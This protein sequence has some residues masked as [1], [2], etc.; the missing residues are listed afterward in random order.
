MH[1]TFS[2]Q[3]IN[4]G[5]QVE[6]DIIKAVS[7][8]VF[9][10][11]CHVYEY[12]TEGYTS[13]FSWVSDELLGGLAAP[14]FMFAMGFGMKYSRNHSLKSQ[15]WRGVKLLTYGQLLNIF[16]YAIP[17]QLHWVITGDESY[18]VSHALNFS[19]D[20]MQFAG[21][22]F[23]LVTLTW[24]LKFS[25]SMTLLLA[26]LMSLI[27]NVL[28]GVQ[29]D[30]YAFD[31]F[32]GVF[33][34]TETESYFPLFNWFLFVAAGKMF[35]K[36]YKRLADKE[37][38]Y[39][40][41]APISALCFAGFIYVT[42]STD[43]GLFRFH[44]VTHHGFCWMRLPDVLACISCFPVMFGICYWISLALP[45]KTLRYVCHPSVYVNQYYNLSWVLIMFVP[46]FYVGTNDWQH[47]LIW[48]FV[49][50]F[51][52]LGVVAYNKWFRTQLETF[53]GH[54]PYFWTAVVWIVSLSFAIYAFVTYSSFPNEF[55]GYTSIC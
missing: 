28:E 26:V 10:I 34:G 23:L 46:F 52:I 48:L 33:W 13:T 41:S 29:T 55:N 5:R 11:L 6:I 53:F 9:M 18:L 39:A 44:E 30:C 45:E 21:L 14:V 7:V 20:I 12:D 25:S 54:H 17:N 37:R 2:Y 32:L 19:S 47:V 3:N 27:G 38:F 15:Y 1:N 50:L 35:G 51:T 24:Q 31:Q 42:S 40:I 43:P 8:V 49:M 16:R 4:T 22:S 36:W